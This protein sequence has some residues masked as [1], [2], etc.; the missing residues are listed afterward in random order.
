MRSAGAGAGVLLLILI[1]AC[2]LQAPAEEPPTPVET[3]ESGVFHRLEGNVPEVR[4]LRLDRAV[5]RL[6][7]AGFPSGSSDTD[8]I[9]DQWIV[10][11]QEP[12]SDQLLFPGERV[13]LRTC[14]ADESVECEAR[15][16]HRDDLALNS[17]VPAVCRSDA[18]RRTVADVFRALDAEDRD[19]LAALLT[20]DTVQI[21]PG[22]RFLLSFFGYSGLDQEGGSA[23]FE[24]EF[25]RSVPGGPAASDVLRGS[26]S[27]DCSTGL[28]T[29]NLG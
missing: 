10:V 11:A 12:D 27:L 26:G 5:A 3:V 18:V 7:A 29:L 6:E 4:G 19:A 28:V 23:G 8:E 15:S 17:G 20:P 2:R 22:E 14:P 24:L 13:G 9:S 1:T 25:R 21:V 16:I